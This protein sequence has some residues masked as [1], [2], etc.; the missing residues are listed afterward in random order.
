MEYLEAVIGGENTT[1][2]KNKTK[3]TKVE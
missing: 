1:N 2:N 3:K